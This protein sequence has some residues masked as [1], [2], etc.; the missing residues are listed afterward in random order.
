MINLP[1]FAQVLLEVL[2][3]QLLWS[4]IGSFEADDRQE[5]FR[6]ALV[7]LSKVLKASKG[8]DEL[9]AAALAEVLRQPIFAADLKPSFFTDVDFAFTS[10]KK[11]LLEPIGQFVAIVADV[12]PESLPALA[13]VVIAAV[14]AFEAPSVEKSFVKSVVESFAM[15]RNLERGSFAFVFKRLLLLS[16]PVT[17]VGFHLRVCQSCAH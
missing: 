3:S 8:Q 11:A 10:T 15:A 14:D 16:Y 12:S 4:F 17:I 7:F 6:S 1:A 2:P 5:Y 13:N 9:A